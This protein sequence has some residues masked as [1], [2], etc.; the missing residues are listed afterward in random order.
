MPNDEND[1]LGFV[2]AQLTIARWYLDRTATTDTVTSSNHVRSARH[3]YDIVVT[4]LPKL[5]IETRP[6]VLAQAHKELAQ[7]RTRLKAAGQAI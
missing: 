5:A 6:D 3:A 7:L 2:R 1:N 4:L